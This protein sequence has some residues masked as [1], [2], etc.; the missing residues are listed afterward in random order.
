MNLE[1]YGPWA[2]A[3]GLVLMTFREVVIQWMKR[4]PVAA[5]SSGRSSE[6]PASQ[7]GLMELA[8]A[9]DKL[10]GVLDRMERA[11]D[12]ALGEISDTLRQMQLTLHEVRVAQ[13]QGR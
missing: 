8:R 7:S 9:V 12:K 3:F 2:I 13:E 6:P 4:E 11:H 5:S 10:A 1:Q